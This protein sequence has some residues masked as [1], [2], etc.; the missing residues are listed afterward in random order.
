M[1]FLLPSFCM[2]SLVFHIG[3]NVNLVLQQT[4]AAFK[5]QNENSYLGVLWY[6][7]GPL[8]LFGILIFVFSQ[9]LGAN[10]E[11]YPLYL[12]LGIISWNFFATSTG[13]SIAIFLTNSSLLKA[14]PIRKELLIV[15]SILHTCISHAL[16]IVLFLALAFS[17]G[18]VP[19]LLPVYLLI[20]IQAVLFSTGVS[21]FLASIFIFLRDINQIW[22]VITRAW[23][24]ATPV[25]YALTPTG[26]GSKL[27][28]FN[29]LYYIIHM[30]REVLI[31]GHIPSA[32]LWFGLGVFTTLSLVVGYT[33][34]SLLHNHF[35]NRL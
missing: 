14:L 26:P 28:W 10:I 35:T 18:V 1:N 19:H 12:L 34:F 9:R 31:Y 23:W 24:F 5:L 6:L 15:S 22:S 2:K 17:Y 21:F 8:L 20:L 25:F 7:L 11:H 32:K 4:K 29:P 3:P 16:E 27:S 30:S 33:T 13:R